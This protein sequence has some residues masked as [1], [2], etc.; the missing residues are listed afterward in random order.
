MTAF[1]QKLEVSF[2]NRLGN[3]ELPRNL[4]PADG[5]TV[6]VWFREAFAYWWLQHRNE[7]LGREWVRRGWADYVLKRSPAG[8][9]NG[10]YCLKPN[11]MQDIDAWV[12]DKID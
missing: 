6:M 4:N 5:P 10:E 9:L 2:V 3:D 12:E 11:R 7:L 1:L 8:E